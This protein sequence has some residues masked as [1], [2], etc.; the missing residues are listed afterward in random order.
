CL[1]KLLWL[2]V[3]SQHRTLKVDPGKLA[4]GCDLHNASVRSPL[5]EHRLVVDQEPLTKVFSLLGQ[6]VTNASLRLMG[7]YEVGVLD[8]SD[9]RSVE[10]HLHIPVCPGIGGALLFFA[11]H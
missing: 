9:M 10:E 3:Q 6:I 7:F 5:D 2:L 1:H 8:L 11:T 4:Q